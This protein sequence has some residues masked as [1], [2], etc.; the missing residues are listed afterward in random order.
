[1]SP[2]PVT[3]DAQG[4]TDPEHSSHLSGDKLGYLVL[5]ATCLGHGQQ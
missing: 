5:L 3:G 1:M 4:S 2:G